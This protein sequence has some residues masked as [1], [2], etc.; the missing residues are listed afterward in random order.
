MKGEARC[1][2]SCFASLAH[3]AGG[4]KAYPAVYSY[5]FIISDCEFGISVMKHNFIME[6]C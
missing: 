6:R 3:S 2:Y 5:D 4:H 1:F